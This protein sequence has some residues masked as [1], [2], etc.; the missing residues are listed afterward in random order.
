MPALPDQ[1]VF[2]SI[3]GPPVLGNV[4]GRPT[5][6][7]NQ[8]DDPQTCLQASPVKAIPSLAAPLAR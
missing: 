2:L 8:K 1:F 5:P 4:L 7:I 6:T 3:L